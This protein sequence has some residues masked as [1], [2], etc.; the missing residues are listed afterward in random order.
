MAMGQDRKRPKWQTETETE[1]ETL[2]LRLLRLRRLRR[3]LLL[4]HLL[5]WPVLVPASPIP[6]TVTVTRG[7]DGTATATATATVTD[8]GSGAPNGNHCD[9]ANAKACN[10]GDN[11]DN[12]NNGNN[13]IGIGI[14]TDSP[15]RTRASG[16]GCFDDNDI[17][18]QQRGEADCDINVSYMLVHCRKTCAICIAED[19]SDSNDT[20]HTSH[21]TNGAIH[22]AVLPQDVGFGRVPW[23]VSIK[24]LLVVR[25]T[26]LYFINNLQRQPQESQQPYQLVTCRD[27]NT[28]CAFWKFQGQCTNQEYASFMEQECPLT[29]QRC[30][31]IKGSA[32]LAFLFQDLAMEYERGRFKIGSDDYEQVAASRRR[33]LSLLMKTMGM[34]PSLVTNTLRAEDG[35]WLHEL[36]TRIHSIIPSVLLRLYTSPDGPISDDDLNLLS[37]LN[38]IP[39][40]RNNLNAH[41]ILMPYRSRGYIVSIMRDLDL[42]VTRPMKLGIAFAVPNEIALQTIANAGPIVQVGA[43]AAYWA[44]LLQHRGVDVVAYDIH[45]PGKDGG[46]N[47]ANGANDRI[48]SN[49]FADVAYMDNIYARACSDVFSPTATTTKEHERT[50]LLIWPNDPD[51]E[52]NPYFCGGGECEGSQAVWDADCLLAFFNAGGEKV[53]YVG[54][55][56]SQIQNNIGAVPDCGISS[57]RRFQQLL[58]THF[59]LVTRIP[60]PNWWLNEDD[61]TVWERRHPVQS[62]KD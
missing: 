6:V 21:H 7:G 9:N 53:I 15:S 40:D 46:R 4:L 39:L 44:A 47:G 14:D 48:G 13:A 35:N 10:N 29:C 57:T 19:A 33:S 37:H 50:L 30:E 52:D 42:F 56:E 49:V 8:T 59:Q 43:G 51:P 26:N 38:R 23:D 41:A 5:V 22:N 54:E 31:F 11:G 24:I 18:C 2:I 3:L 32:F 58:Q 12:G 17:I 45:P 20:N 60:I 28:M 16:N 27:S 61:L 55:R 62:T 1:T 34:D 25:Q 36:H